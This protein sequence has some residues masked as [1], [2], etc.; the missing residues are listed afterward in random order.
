[1]YLT[2][3]NYTVYKHYD[4]RLVL[5]SIDGMN[6]DLVILDIMMPGVDGFTMC[7]LIFADIRNMMLFKKKKR[8]R[9]RMC[10]NT[11]SFVSI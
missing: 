11:K 10:W 2:N 1:M 4:P 7:K 6:L 8:Y 3:E 5:D 9:M